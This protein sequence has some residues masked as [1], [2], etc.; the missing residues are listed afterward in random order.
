MKKSRSRRQVASGVTG[1]GLYPA[2]LLLSLVLTVGVFAGESGKSPEG[3]PR[4]REEQIRAA[5]PDKARVVPKQKR[6]VLIWSTPAH[7]MDKDPHKGYCVPYGLCAMRI[8][9]E[10]TGAFEPVI[11]DDIAE[12]L[13]ENI[14]RFDAIV[15]NNSCGPWIT[16]SDAAMDRLKAYGQTKEA[17]EKVLRQSLL[18]YVANGGGIV[19]YHY[20][21]GANAHWPEF[22]QLLGA[23]FIGHPWNEEVA[24]LVEEPEHPLVAAFG[25]KNFRIADEIFHFGPP[26]DRQNVRVL[27]SLDTERTN[28]GV[29]WI[30]RE[31]NDFAQTWVKSVGKGRVFYSGFGHRTEIW[32]N[33]TILQF[34]L[35]AIQFAVG[36]MEAP[37]GR[38]SSPDAGAPGHCAQ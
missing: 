35:D 22:R 19:A 10:K 24:V 4:D 30:Q 21:I 38:A 36:D 18:D 12:F 9:G 14:H 1:S 32:W 16:P 26:Y 28:M 29:M 31:D 17:V 33:P 20:A 37:T 34:Y 27:L 8:L 13:P 11:H 23:T 15:M 3:I 6:R 2:A 5:A 7:L 25:G